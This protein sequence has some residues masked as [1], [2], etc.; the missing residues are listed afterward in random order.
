MREKH[1]HGRLH[2]SHGKVFH[3]IA[4]NLTERTKADLGVD[5]LLNRGYAKEHF[6]RGRGCETF[7]RRKII[8][9]I[10]HLGCGRACLQQVCDGVFMHFERFPAIFW[11]VG[12]NLDLM[13][14]EKIWRIEM[15]LFV[16]TFLE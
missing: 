14:G 10:F 7:E 8:L 16:A 5:L 11:I 15:H 6:G 1:V 3:L 13:D 12:T 9:D 4:E 2:T